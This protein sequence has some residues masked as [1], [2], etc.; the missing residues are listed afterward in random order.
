[1]SAKNAEVKKV[2]MSLNDLNIVKKCDD[3]FEFEY[4]SETTGKG[5]GVFINVL[6]S[7]SPKVQGYVRRELNDLR[8]QAEMAK[9]RGKEIERSIED[10]EGFSNEAAAIRV[11]GWRGI[12]E[13]YSPELAVQ[14]IASNPIIRA[15]IYAA[16]NDLENFTKG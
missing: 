12:T 4:I 3:A 5:T 9:K 10:D 8:K 7:H 6:G 1:M 14:L 16:S 2:S 15:Q 13:D 11:I